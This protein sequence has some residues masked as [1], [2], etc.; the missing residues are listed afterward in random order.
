[1]DLIAESE[2]KHNKWLTNG[3]GTA[4]A[5]V[6]LEAYLSFITILSRS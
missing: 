4:A 2:H 5:S 3:E 6:I 1:M